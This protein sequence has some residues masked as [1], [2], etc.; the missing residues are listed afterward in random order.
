MA[1]KDL[2]SATDEQLNQFITDGFTKSS[3][4]RHFGLTSTHTKARAYVTSRL[5]S[6]SLQTQ[7]N[8]HHRTYNRDGFVL[9]ANESLCWSDVCKALNL[10]VCGHNYKV[11]QQFA[12]YHNIDVSHFDVKETFR[13]NKKAYTYDEIYCE[14]SLFSRQMLNRKTK[15]LK[16][17]E[18]KCEK[19]GNDGTW[20]G[21]YLGLE[22]DHKNGVHD[23]NRVDNLRWLCPN[24]H[25][26]TSTYKG[27]NIK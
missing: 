23:D 6:L 22:L 7:H 11:L 9:A 2:T 25:S 19:C 26:Q 8:Q 20:C 5:N 12:T 18:Y 24:C 14:H 15:Q 21:E 27:K 3:I 13:R 10:T 1:Y 16:V 4:L 17:L